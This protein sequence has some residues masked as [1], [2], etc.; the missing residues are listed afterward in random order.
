[1]HHS[2][3]GLVFEVTLVSYYLDGLDQDR[4]ILVILLKIEEVL[5]ELAEQQPPLPHRPAHQCKK[6]LELLLT[7]KRRHQGDGSQGYPIHS[8]GMGE[9]HLQSR[10]PQHHL[11]SLRL[12]LF[13]DRHF[14]LCFCIK[15]ISLQYL[16]LLDGLY[17]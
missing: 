11:L 3:L 15:V 1:M 13:D 10:I 12:A 17:E 16:V 5:V 14:H 7:S 9:Q 6:M 2:L 4:Y 8:V